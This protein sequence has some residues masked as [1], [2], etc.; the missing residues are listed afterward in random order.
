MIAERDAE[1]QTARGWMNG[2]INPA[3]GADGETRTVLLVDD[4]ESLLFALGENL[5]I[6]GFAVLTASN[7]LEALEVARDNV[8]RI[9][10][11]LLDIAMPV[12]DGIRAF[13][14][15]RQVLPEAKI[16]IHTAWGRDRDVQRLLEEGADGLLV[17]PVARRTIAEEFERVLRTRA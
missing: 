3:R 6:L 15:L 11:V 7:G 17:K 2:D 13:P 12:M 4:E 14:L 9:D 1:R 5:R 8:A 10:L 16:V